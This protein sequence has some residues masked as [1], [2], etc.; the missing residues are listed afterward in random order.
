M[1]AWQEKAISQSALVCEQLQLQHHRNLEPQKLQFHARWN[2]ITG[3]NGSGKTALLEALY[4]LSRGKSFRSSKHQHVIRHGQSALWLYSIWQRQGELERVGLQREAHQ[5]RLHLNEQPTAQ[6]ALA[7]RLPLQLIHH[8]GLDL[9]LDSP[10]VRR[11]LLD[12]GV[13]YHNPLF[14]HHWQRYHH[15]LKQ[16]NAAL[17]GQQTWL[18]GWYHWL[19][20]HGLAIDSY[21]REYL[22]ALQSA[23][24]YYHHHL[25]G[26]AE[27][28]LRY[29]RGFSEAMSLAECL[30][31]YRERDCKLGYVK[32]G[33][34]RADIGFYAQGQNVAHCYSRGEQKTLISALLLAQAFL[35]REKTGVM[36]VMLVDDVG[37]ELDKKRQA[38]L[39]HLLDESGAQCFVT[40]L[41]ALD[42][43]YEHKRFELENGVVCAL[44]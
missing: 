5:Y 28:E 11:R 19:L 29:Q 36:P 39:L 8:E 20:E 40:H 33:V 32:D 2:L 27:I 25:G 1:N 18:D 34:H 9:A 15:A 44:A 6:S 42:L 35:I 12:Y 14:L 3:E 23:L 26:L 43:P 31:K 38:L 7:Q 37:A 13:F 30:E 22:Q 16:L 17:R 4:L 10:E 41:N 24:N 21:R